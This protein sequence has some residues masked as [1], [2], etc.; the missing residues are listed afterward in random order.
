M[1]FAPEE[2]VGPLAGF[3]DSWFFDS[4]LS[5]MKLIVGLGNPGSPYERT[6]HNVGFM[7]VDRLAQRYGATNFRAAHEAFL[8]DILVNGEKLILL[9]PQTYMNL[10]GRSVASAMQ[11]YKLFLDDLLV[12]V[13]DIALPVGMLRLRAS[14][15]SGG[16]NGLKDIE[17]AVSNIAAAT[18]KLP[19]DYQRLR[20]GIDPPGP[21]PQKAYVLQAFTAEQLPRLDAALTRGVEAVT[22]W[23]ADGIQTAM[24]QFNPR[25]KDPRP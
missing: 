8:A 3:D 18:G 17:R 23:A 15:S 5:A 9:K 13:D 16:H 6:R 14:G 1:R 19:V 25:E 12:I 21:V 10:A 4:W 22:T 20:I 7:L 11:F 2:G 24:N